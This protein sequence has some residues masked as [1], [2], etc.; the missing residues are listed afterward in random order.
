[1]LVLRLVCDEDNTIH[2]RVYSNQ[3]SLSNYSLPWTIICN[4]TEIRFHS[5]S[6]NRV[7]IENPKYEWFVYRSSL[8]PLSSSSFFSVRSHSQLLVIVCQSHLIHTLGSSNFCSINNT[9]PLVT[10]D[11]SIRLTL[12]LKFESIWRYTNENVFGISYKQLK[13]NNCRC[14]VGDTHYVYYFL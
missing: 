5:T 12:S 6:I 1:M 10:S 7:T 3:S 2:V 4:L 14:F 13:V 11:P 8:L 9:A